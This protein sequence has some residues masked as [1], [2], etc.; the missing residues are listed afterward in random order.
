MLSS[1]LKINETKYFI[2]ELLNVDGI[3]KVNEA[4]ILQKRQKK[5][6]N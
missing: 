2:K 1:N 3:I 6:L 5:F 4:Q